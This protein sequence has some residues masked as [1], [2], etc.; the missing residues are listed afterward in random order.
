MLPQKDDARWA[1]FIEELA[2]VQVKDLAAQMMIKGLKLKLKQD[3]TEEAKAEAIH[4]AY[5][6][7]S[8][9]ETAMAEDIHRI[10]G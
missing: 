7:F 6:F 8:K 4:T 9:N 3:G 5:E 10:F 1:R 2:Q